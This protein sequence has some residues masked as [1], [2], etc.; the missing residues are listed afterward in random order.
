MRRQARENKSQLT[1]C[2]RIPPLPSRFQFQFQPLLR[3]TENECQVS[4]CVCVCVFELYSSVR[5]QLSGS[6]WLP[7]VSWA[8]AASAARSCTSTRSVSLLFQITDSPYSEKEGYNNTHTHTHEIGPVKNKHEKRERDW[9]MSPTSE[10][11]PCTRTSRQ[12]ATPVKYSKQ[13]KAKKGKRVT[14]KADR[15]KGRQKES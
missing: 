14:A 11:A 7:K 3:P 13:S 5:Q 8:A 1:E 4:V 15:E 12:P 6:K 2:K 10:A 9:K